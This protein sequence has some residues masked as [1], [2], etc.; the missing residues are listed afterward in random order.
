M[1][2]RPFTEEDGEHY[3]TIKDPDGHL[4]HTHLN[5]IEAEAIEDFI[6]TEKAMSVLYNAARIT[7][8]REPE[9]CASWEGYEA[10]GYRTAKVIITELP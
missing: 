4:I 7:H 5:T 9:C 2:E 3:W 8:G 6:K 1:S 10:Q